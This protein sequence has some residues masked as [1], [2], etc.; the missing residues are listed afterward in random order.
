[1]LPSLLARE[2]QNGVRHFL[3]SGFEPSDPL[4]AGVVQRFIEDEARWI[5]GP[6]VQV[7]L[8][9]RAGAHGTGFWDRFVMAHPGFFHQEAAWQR[10]ASDRDADNMLVAT[11][12]GS[13]K[14]ECFLY[15]V[16]DHCARANASAE[17][18]IKALVVYPMN[19][20]ATDQA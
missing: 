5:K 2:I 12:T 20:L 10:F 1:M 4:F 7:G 8:P 16:L 14:T 13:G 15:P 11:G 18:G 3:T 17:A 9:F 19:A 6:Y